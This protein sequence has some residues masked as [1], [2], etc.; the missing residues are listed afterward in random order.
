MV[1]EGSGGIRIPQGPLRTVP[2]MPQLLLLISSPRTVLALLL[3]KIWMCALT[4]RPSTK[5]LVFALCFFSTHLYMESQTILRTLELFNYPRACCLDWFQWCPWRVRELLK[6]FRLS[7]FNFS[8]SSSMVGPLTCP[9]PLSPTFSY[10]VHSMCI[11]IRTL[12]H[13]FSKTEVIL[14]YSKLSIDA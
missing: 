9:R 12:T 4:S 6:S 3:T 13:L 7:I 14:V 8:A 2:L 1:D 5:R 11:A 10:G